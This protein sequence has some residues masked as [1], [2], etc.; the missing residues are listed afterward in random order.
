MSTGVTVLRGRS[1]C[2]R[3][4]F[5][6]AHALA[7][8]ACVAVMLGWPFPCAFSSP[9]PESG[10]SNAA[11]EIAAVDAFDNIEWIVEHE[12]ASSNIPGAVVLIGDR[13]HILYRRAF[14]R[15]AIE[16]HAEA[17]TIDTIFDL[18][19]L[20][21]V[22]ATTTAIM[23]LLEQGKLRL[24]D[25]AGRYWPAFS[26]HGKEA[27]T[28]RELLTHTSG[29]AAD[30]DLS[31]TW[32][33]RDATLRRI[34]AQRPF[35]LPGR[36]YLYSD[37]NFIVLGELVRRVSGL[38]LDA[39]C[40]QH[41]F[42]PL[43]MRDTSFM[44]PFAVR[45]RI[46]PTQRLHGR[47]LRGIVH[48][49]TARR[50][51]GV[52]GHAG[53]FSTAD[54][55]ARFAQALLDAKTQ[56]VASAVLLR[57]ST[58]ASMILPER[59]GPH[60]FRALGWDV[61]SPFVANWEA[62]PPLG[63]FGHTGYTGTALWIDPL[64]GRFLI[65]LT[66]RVHP[67]G[68]GDAQPLRAA[69]AQLLALSGKA[70]RAEELPTPVGAP[71]LDRQAMADSI[72]P[73]ST[74]R[75]GIDVL[76]ADGFAELQG[77]R[78]GLITN[79]TGRTGTGERTLDLLRNAPGVHLAAVLTP[80]HGL[81]GQA[82][83]RV[84]DSIDEASGLPVYSL[85]GHT[86]RPTEAMLAGLDALLFDVQDSGTRF[87]TYSTTM[88]YA[89]QAAAHAG[90]RFIVV[91]RPDPIDA[92]L[93]QGPLLDARRRSFTGYFPLP[94]RHGMT[95]GELARL[96]NV[97]GRIGVRLQVIPMQHY[98]RDAWYDETGLPW[99]RLSPN[100]RT[101]AQATLYPGVA[102][103]EGA[104]LSVGRGTDWPF[105]LL[106]APWIDG[107]LLASELSRRDIPGVRF[108]PAAFTPTADR[109]RN[110]PCQGVRLL[111]VDRR[112][113]DAGRLAVE[114]EAA[115]YRLYPT[116]F[117][118]ER[119]LSLLGSE[120]VLQAIKAGKDP[121][122]ITRNWQLSLQAFLSL[123]AHYLLYP[124]MRNAAFRPPRSDGNH[125]S[126]DNRSPASER[127]AK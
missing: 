48:D 25:P 115:L 12:I 91:D 98:A 78:V 28:I 32:T 41:I 37:L 101:L 70:V 19:S 110:Q 11:P 61:G 72:A 119:T 52:A 42:G 66:N 33:G 85:Y 49:P 34:E 123:R 113:F 112:V 58:L 127:G 67:D 103:V 124:Q 84:P 81:D 4:S 75:T 74:L 26:A 53:L 68:R 92:G 16:P 10:A 17:M 117:E 38:P 109:Y 80:E 86:T 31:R 102:V 79:Q 64:S 50:M 77:L 94:L 57:P 95:V 8:V 55:L 104:N 5:V 83:G 62:L 122:A 30:L 71:V 116:R 108:V 9:L 87:Y 114:L 21:K 63:A 20:T 111:L 23:Q 76:A 45:T 24:D 126:M 3:Q 73:N 22:V 69:V 96:F 121:I 27:I 43:G 18:A 59:V 35:W 44:P 51:G 54:D 13:D 99:V 6:S 1:S 93:V 125:I 82:D 2:R 65:L 89:M 7:W 97:E 29:L 14:G 106:G 105:E 56:E 39:Y 120:S 40:T 46:A 90:L 118:I 60:R 36:Q 100:L 15:R 47:W 88:A 107:G